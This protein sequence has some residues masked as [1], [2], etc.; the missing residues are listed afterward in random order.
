MQKCVELPSNIKLVELEKI[1]AAAAAKNTCKAS[2][3]IQQITSLSKIEGPSTSKIEIWN[4]LLRCQNNRQAAVGYADFKANSAAENWLRR[5][6]NII[7]PQSVGTRSSLQIL[8]SSK[9]CDDSCTSRP[10]LSN[11]MFWLWTSFTRDWWSTRS[12]VWLVLSAL[13]SGHSP[14]RR[15]RDRESR[16]SS[17]TP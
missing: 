12:M 8:T 13:W 16:H 9:R 5:N 3:S 4:Y 14:Y 10:G 7:M 6:D 17:S 11:K 15:S 2:A 1:D